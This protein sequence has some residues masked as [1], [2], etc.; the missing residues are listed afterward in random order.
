M[1]N[2]K[3]YGIASYDMNIMLWEKFLLKFEGSLNSWFVFSA[4]FKWIQAHQSKKKVL[5]SSQSNCLHYQKTYTAWHP[6]QIAPA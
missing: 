6:F 1:L 4:L 3:F 2:F 5:S